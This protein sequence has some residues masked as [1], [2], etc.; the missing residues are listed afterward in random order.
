MSFA[1]PARPQDSLRALA[2]TPA[3]TGYEQPLAQVIRERLKGRALQQDNLGNL[4]FTVGSGAPHRLVVAPMDEPGYVVSGITDDGYLRVHRLPQQAPHGLFDQLHAAQP[5][6]IH[7]RRGRWVSGVVAGLSTHLQGGRRD[8]PRVTHPDEIYVDIGASSRAEVRQAGVDLLDPVALERTFR[9]MGHGKRAAMGVGDKFGAAA[10]VELTARLDPGRIS[11]TLTI[12]FAAQQGAASRGLDRLLQHVKADEMIY[13]GRLLARRG[14]PGQQ[15]AEGQP[16][17][18]RK[19]PGSGVLVGVERPDAEPA[20]LAAEIMQRARQHGITLSADYSAAL[21]RVSYTRGPVL[22]ERFAHLGIATAWPWTPAELLDAND[23][24]QLVELLDAYVHTAY[25]KKPASG[26]AGSRAEGAPTARPQTA[27]SMAEILKRLVETYGVSGHEGPVRE[28]IA[29]L[30]PPWAK[31]ETDEMGNLILRF[32]SAPAE[33]AGTAGATL[34]KKPRIMF[35]AHSDEIGYVVRSIA[36]DGRLVVQ[37]RGGGII[38]FF[39][40]HPLLVRTASGVRPGVMELP[41]GWDQPNFEWPRGPQAVLRVDVGARSAAEAGELGIR[42]G[43]PITVPKKYRPLF[44]RRANGRSFDDRVGSAAL[45]AAAWALG[46]NVPGREVTFVWA[47]QEEVGLLGALGVAQAMAKEGQAPDYVFAVDTFVSSDSPLE[48]RRFAH[49]PIGKGF[50]VRAVD[51]SNIVRRD[52]VDRV[53]RLA[54]ANGIAAQYGVT[55]GGNDGAAFLRH[56]TFDIPV[57]WPLRYSHSPG[58]VID[59]RDAEALAR[60]VAVLAKEW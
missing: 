48:S 40:G 14:G 55:G 49:A 3:V 58:E 42:A 54:R 25:E 10:L 39:A 41:A 13:V 24:G 45:V 19:E 1:A 51:N 23:W 50:V 53:V 29:R 30:L 28:E 43:D 6:V 11:G 59:V 52:F 36:D 22:P 56:G 38:E 33:G 4:Y 7:T 26:S 5:V 32:G 20:G 57:S 15:Q 27:P 37:S 46:P 47:V 31:P 8:A 21:P 17:A 44:G 35:V 2:E 9:E 34:R 60:I 16:R 18:P 12:A